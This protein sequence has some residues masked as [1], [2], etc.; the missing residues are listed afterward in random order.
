M[1]KLLFSFICVVVSLIV[2]IF[3]FF[4]P[5]VVVSSKDKSFNKKTPCIIIDAGHGGF[6]GGASTDD[7]YPEK[8]INLNISIYLSDYLTALGYETLLTRTTDESLEDSGLSTIRKRKTSDLHNRMKIMEETENAIFIS[9]HQNHYSQE[10]YRGMQVFYSPSFS[11]ESS[12]LAE[13]IQSCTVNTLQPDNTRKIKECTSSV[14]L[15]YKA[16]KPAVL[17][18]CGFLSNKEEAELLQT[19]KYQKNIALCIA[20]GV[21]NYLSSI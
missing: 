16:V 12:A 7:G 2:F 15:I 1:K 19:E 3:S 21:Q 17:V 4:T 18:E 20:M 6:D 5:E 9:I 13:Y 11:D 14:F 8:H 10:K